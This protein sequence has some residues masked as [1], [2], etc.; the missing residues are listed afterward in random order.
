MTPVLYASACIFVYASIC[1][2]ESFLGGITKPHMFHCLNLNLVTTVLTN[3]N[4]NIYKKVWDFTQKYFL[5]KSKA[6]Y[7]GFVKTNTFNDERITSRKLILSAP[8]LQSYINWHTCMR[9]KFHFSK[10]SFLPWL[11]KVF[12]Q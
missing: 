3:H 5:L 4:L 9:N 7:N 2:Q 10:S 6:I 12:F 8:A 1:N 11:T